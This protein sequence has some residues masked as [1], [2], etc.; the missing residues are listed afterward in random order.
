MARKKA[1]AKKTTA[2]KA[3]RGIRITKGSK[4]TLTARAGKKRHFLATVL[5]TFV[6]GGKRIALLSVPARAPE[7]RRRRK[8]K[9]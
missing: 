9:A 3:T 2:K 6:I 1:S 5:D 7:Q 4:W 8:P